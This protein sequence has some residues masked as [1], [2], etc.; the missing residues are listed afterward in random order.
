[1]VEPVEVCC[2]VMAS[3]LVPDVKT[4]FQLLAQLWA[5]NISGIQLS[6]SLACGSE[7]FMHGRCRGLRIVRFPSL[8]IELILGGDLTWL[9]TTQSD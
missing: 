4:S 9:G 6:S 3:S 2:W 8:Y 5:S 1:M 7:H